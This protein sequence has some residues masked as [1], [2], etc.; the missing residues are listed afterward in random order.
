MAE[1]IRLQQPIKLKK[2]GAL[3][4]LTEKDTLAGKAARVLTSKKTTAAL[5][6]TLG[7][8]VAPA[9]T[10]A[11]VGSAALKV[12]KFAAPKT[13]GGAVKAAIAV[14]V[15]AGVLSSSA[16]ARNIVSK[17]INPLENIKKGQKIGEIVEDPSKASEILGLNKE[18]STKDKIITGLKTAGAV[19]AVTAAGVAA[20]AAY[21]KYKEKKSQENVLQQGEQRATELEN[22][23]ENL[24]LAAPYQL[25]PGGTAALYPASAVTSTEGA[26]QSQI[27]PPPVQNIIQIAVR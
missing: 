2:K 13:L 6:T 21:K 11:K 20:T 25:T 24:G 27:S 7:F 16:T 10:A 3:E 17:A 8:M 23:L 18:S 12:A 4:E 15:A 26:Q 1:V 19:G 14:P 22:P 5:A 9:G